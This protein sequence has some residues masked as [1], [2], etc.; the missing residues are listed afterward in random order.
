MNIAVLLAGGTDPNFKMNIPKQFVN[1][2]NRP[3]IVYTMEAFQRHSEI[4]A[5]MVACLSGWEKMVEAYAKQFNID[6][7][8]WIITGGSNGQETSR[9]AVNEL[10]K[11]CNDDDIV[12]IHD[13][14]RPLVTNE[15][16]S[17]SIH[18]CRKKG[19]GIAAVTSMENVMLTDDGVTGLRSISRY[20]FKR[21][22]TPQTYL[23][24]NLRR[25][26]EEALE[27][28][29]FGEVDTNNMV[30][31][32]GKPISLSKGSDLNIKINTVEDVEMFKALY[33]MIN[34]DNI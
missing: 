6:K 30:S 15:V 4:D 14:I 7:L 32:L 33:N 31:K 8:R 13:A 22:Q 24:G 18:I 29:V 20:A 26:H 10:D 23:L 28:A 16:I 27:Q 19:M 34:D 3:I 1:V 5:I 25:Y 2:Y 9:L 21:I 17:D 11:C 12:V